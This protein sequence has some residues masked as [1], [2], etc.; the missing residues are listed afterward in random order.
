MCSD[1][2]D[3]LIDRLREARVVV[4]HATYDRVAELLAKPG[5]PKPPLH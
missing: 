4:N 1:H 2:G 5:K 3:S